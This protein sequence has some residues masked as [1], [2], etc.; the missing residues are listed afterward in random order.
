VTENDAVVMEV[1]TLAPSPNFQGFQGSPL[2]PSRTTGP[3]FPDEIAL[4]ARI[5][6][7]EE[8]AV[9]ELRELIAGGLKW[10]IVRELGHDKVEDYVERAFLAII[11][12]IREGGLSEPEHLRGYA[13]SVART[14]AMTEDR[15]SLQSRLDD[16]DAGEI[17]KPPKGPPP[18]AV[19]RKTIRAMEGVIAKIPD[20]YREALN[21]FYIGG[22]SADEICRDLGLTKTEFDGVRSGTKRR[23]LANSPRSLRTSASMAAKLRL[24]LKRPA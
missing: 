3:C 9:S 15:K 1:F 10:F 22:H 6:N 8:S 14:V 11:V 12:G 20:R 17:G 23:Y 21:R 24:L 19:D 4:V 5:R 2:V 7:H 13:I 18:S 16:N